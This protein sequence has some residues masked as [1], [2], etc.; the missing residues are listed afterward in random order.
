MEPGVRGEPLQ[1]GPA[2]LGVRESKCKWVATRLSA[3]LRTPVVSARHK[4]CSVFE[5]K[6]EEEEEGKKEES[7]V[8]PRSGATSL[9]F[10]RQLKICF[11]VACLHPTASKL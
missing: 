11:Y 5:G 6:V 7:G 3:G 4:M 8:Q 10:E 2:R 9:M 1:L